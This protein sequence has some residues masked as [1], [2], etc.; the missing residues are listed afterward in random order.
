VTDDPAVA[1]PQEQPWR[2]L[3][4]LVAG[5]LALCAATVLLPHDPYIRYQQLRP[6]IQFRTVWVYERLVFDRTPIDVAIIGNSRLQA[7]ISAPQLQAELSRKLGRPVHVANLSLPQEGRN[8][9]FAIAKTLFQTHPEVQLVIMSAIE[10]MPRQGHPAFRN[11]ADAGDIVRALL[12]L[13]SEYFEDLAYL[14][15]RQLSLFVQTQFPKAFGLNASFNPA[16]YAGAGLDTTYSFDTPTGN[17]VDRDAVH[18]AADLM[19]SARERAT[20]IT[21]RL[22]PG[23]AAEQEFVKERTYT[24][25]IAGLAQRKGTR[26]AF[27]YTPIFHFE[28]P[29]TDKDFYAA[30]GPVLEARFV[31][32]DPRNFSDYGHVN[33][34]GAV[35]VTRWLGERIVADGLL[36]RP[37][38]P[39]ANATPTLRN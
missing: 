21:P 4:L 24:R 15:Y 19:P 31:A 5:F 18:P 33:R 28:M 30:R 2:L 22:L 14:P 6:T 37:A 1:A 23:W 12:L 32:A 36:G 39:A 7:S 3:A 8:A 13:N 27:L 10:Q 9:Q 16:G 29:V 35:K 38:Q 26:S 34:I 17:H 20:S 25:R 11:I